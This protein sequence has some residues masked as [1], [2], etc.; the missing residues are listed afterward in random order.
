MKVH[1]LNLCTMCPYGGRLIEGGDKGITEIGEMVVHA[2]LVETNDGLVVVDTGMGLDDVRAPSGRLGGAFVALCR[3]QLREEDTAVRQVERLGFRREDVRHVVVTHL[4]VDH[5]GGIPD[6]PAAKIHV[7]KK[8][9]AA[10]M[11]PSFRERSR[12]RKVH[13]DGDPKWELHE[14]GGD[15]WFGFASVQ[16]VA[17]DVLMIPLFGHT[18]GH[19]AIAVRARSPSRARAEWL[20]HCGD[21]YFFHEELFDPRRCPPGLAVFQRAIAMDDDARRA[22]ARRL[23][24]LHE[25]AGDQIHIFSAHSP[26]E[27]RAATEI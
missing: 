20:L 9:H 8:E 23:R 26:H 10:A 17:D 14:E 18:R 16:A 27:Y 13:F 1:H 15:T 19:C 25:E 12:Y 3:P 21:A 5:A 22:N 24:A 2:L 4:D 7:H 11:K 6:F